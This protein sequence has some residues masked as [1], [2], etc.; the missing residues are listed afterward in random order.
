[1]MFDCIIGL[2][3]AGV[4]IATEFANFEEYP[5]I[6]RLDSAEIETKNSKCIDIP[7]SSQIRVEDFE[8]RI[9]N[10]KKYFKK[11]K[12]KNKVL[13]VLCG[14]GAISMASL[15]IL[16]Q[17]PSRNITVLY[18][19]P[20]IEFLGAEAKLRENLSFNVFQEYARSGLF[21]RLYIISNLLI[22]S[23]MGGVSIISYFDKINKTIVNTFY[24]MNRFQNMKPVVA[25]TSELDIGTRISTFGL[26]DEETK[27]EK[28]FYY[29][30]IPTDVVYYFAYNE[31]VL[32]SDVSLLSQ[33][34]NTVKEKIASGISSVSYGVF[35][36]NYDSAFIICTCH[37][38]LVQL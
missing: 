34:K 12:D 22:E 26:V 2:G 29:L 17:I 31:S 25:T 38:S 10:L 7:L 11:I 24:M 13:F 37:T 4:A 23:A 16:E 21:T 18:I 33:I 5:L 1:M 36:T 35:A 3:Q 30:D 20:D 14:G 27:E 6:Y 19:R 15:A 8:E 9:P 28:M 32:K